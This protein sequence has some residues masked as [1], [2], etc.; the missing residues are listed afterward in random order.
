MKIQ[1]TSSVPRQREQAPKYSSHC[2][3][4]GLVVQS[5]S[6]AASVVIAIVVVVLFAAVTQRTAGNHVLGIPRAFRRCD[7][8]DGG[9]VSGVAA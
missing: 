1:M 5:G 6:G 9:F 7:A 2:L 3:C 4:I 8:G